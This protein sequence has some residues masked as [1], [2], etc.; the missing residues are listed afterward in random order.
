MNSTLSKVNKGADA[1][2]ILHVPRNNPWTV[3]ENG[4]AGSVSAVYST[5]QPD[6][7][8]PQVTY[9]TKDAKGKILDEGIVYRAPGDFLN[10]L[11]WESTVTKEKGTLKLGTISKRWSWT[12]DNSKRTGSM[13]PAP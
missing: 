9:V 3:V 12:V 8:G 11:I 2:N 13:T 5:S 4:V 7:H 6:Q 1:L 10:H